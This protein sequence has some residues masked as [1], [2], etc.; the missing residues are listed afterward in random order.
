MKT[1]NKI[2]LIDGDSAVYVFS[3]FN[4]D[5]PEE[6][7]KTVE[8]A[9]D[10]WVTAILNRTDA[11][12][13]AGFLQGPEKSHR[14]KLFESYKGNRSERPEW[15]TR[16]KDTI[17]NRLIERWKFQLVNGQEV[18]DAIASAHTILSL[19]A[20][21]IICSTDK[22]YKQLPGLFYNPQK[23]ILF[24]V[25]DSEAEINL[26]TQLIT[27]DSTDNIKGVPGAGPKTAE[28]LLKNTSKDLAETVLKFFIAYH[29]DNTAE[30][31]LDFANTAIQ[32]VLKR[33]KEFK[34][35]TIEVK[36]KKRDINELFN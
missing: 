26:L 35:E 5:T 6:D 32:I 18:D 24:N 20:D 36:E 15:V 28:K 3:Y 1:V 27:G 22:D 4:R 30:G 17:Y 19:K 16:W 21:P 23:D 25:T 31:L 12:E 13:Y 34:F 11:D 7:F 33:D 8:D 9:V 29:N 10:N 14:H 2:A